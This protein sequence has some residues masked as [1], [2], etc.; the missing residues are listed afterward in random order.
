MFTLR[1]GRFM[2]LLPSLDPNL[3]VV[4]LAGNRLQGLFFYII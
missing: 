3:P 1:V 4:D 2:L